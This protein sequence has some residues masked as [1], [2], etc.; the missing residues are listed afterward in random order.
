MKANHPGR[1]VAM[2]LFQDG[3]PSAV[4]KIASDDVGR[5]AL[6]READ[7]LASLAPLL[8]PP[9]RAP[10][11]LHRDEGILLLEPV[12]WRPRSRPWA[13]P[14]QAARALGT[15]FAAGRSEGGTG[16]AHGDFAP[17]NLLV[18]ERDWVVVDWEDSR[19]EAPPF[20][21]VFHY[22]VQSCALLGRPSPDA[23]A[24]GLIEREG[25]IAT[26][27]RAYAEGAGMTVD[28]LASYFLDYLGL[29]RSQVDTA[30]P[31]G[32]AG[33]RVRDELRSRVGQ[34]R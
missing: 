9:L 7:A 23:V 33:A 20:F 19:P 10:R 30:T 1:F 21:D 5:V 13:L 11:L 16:P 2:I 31:D 3:S 27:I 15:F 26:V 25:A 8:P 22:L 24:R 34:L 6:D 32:R 17:W 14:V 29:S 28:D 18:T 12:A 4:A